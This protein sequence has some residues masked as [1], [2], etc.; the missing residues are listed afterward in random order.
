MVVH[1]HIHKYEPTPNID[2]YYSYSYVVLPPIIEQH[3]LIL[4]IPLLSLHLQAFS[5][6]QRSL[7][8]NGA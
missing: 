4:P 7:L 8:L 2:Y 3:R 6:C 1:I 5:K